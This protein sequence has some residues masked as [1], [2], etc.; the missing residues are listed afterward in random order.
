MDMCVYVKLCI[1]RL[2][3]ISHLLSISSISCISY[4]FCILWKLCMLCILCIV[5][6]LCLITMS[7]MY[8]IY[9]GSD[10]LY[11]WRWVDPLYE[12]FFDLQMYRKLMQL[13]PTLKRNYDFLEPI[14]SNKHF[15]ERHWCH[16]SVLEETEDMRSL[17]LWAS[18]GESGRWRIH[19]LYRMLGDFFELPSFLVKNASL[20]NACHS[21]LWKM[22]LTFEISN[23]KHAFCGAPFFA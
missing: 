21:E 5:C 2:L 22:M 14:F 20:Q 9:G 12:G 7:I 15:V 16:S 10:F 8:I 6:I 19:F 11:L 17:W 1:S 4:I 3:K 18:L 23:F 13:P